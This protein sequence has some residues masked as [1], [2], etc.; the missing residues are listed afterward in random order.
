MLDD[1]AGCGMVC[2]GTAGG[3]ENAART[4]CESGDGRRDE[5]VVS[6]ELGKGS[7]FWGARL[8]CSLRPV[9]EGSAESEGAIG[10]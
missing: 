5:T 7:W 3:R 1:G 10:K 6:F 2:D 8:D 4:G 9:D